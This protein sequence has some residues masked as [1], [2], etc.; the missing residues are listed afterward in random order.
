MGQPQRPPGM[1]QR[2]APGQPGRHGT[3]YQHAPRSG[4]GRSRSALARHKIWTGFG[5]FIVLGVIVYALTP[6]PNNSGHASAPPAATASPSNAR[7]SPSVAST[8]LAPLSVRNHAGAILTAAVNYY[9]STF[10]RGQ[11]MVGNTQYPNASVGLAAM[12]NPDSA[13]SRFAEWRKST[14][15]E[16]NVSTYESAF[17]RAD[18]GFNASDEPASISQWMQDAGNL[19][20]DISQWINVVVSYQISTAS[21]ANLDAAA[22]TVRTDIKDARHDI[23][24]VRRGK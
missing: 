7:P 1:D 2:P 18:A 23:S 16:E 15:I 9:A 22:A 8:Y 14:G 12:E 3:G 5:I 19:Q 20:G 17:S 10:A 6:R 21:Q 13:A 11:A 4:Q 24:L